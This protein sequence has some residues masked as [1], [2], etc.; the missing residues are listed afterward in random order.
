MEMTVHLN[1]DWQELADDISVCQQVL[2]DDIGSEMRKAFNKRE[3][4]KQLVS[5][6]LIDTPVGL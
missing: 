5:Q 1:L 6:I 4:E 2:G 3:G